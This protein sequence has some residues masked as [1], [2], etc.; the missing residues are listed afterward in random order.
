MTIFVSFDGPKGVG[1]TTVIDSVE[2]ELRT[3]CSVVRFAE[4]DLDPFRG[5]SRQLL[6]ALPE[7]G[8]IS[9]EMEAVRLLARGRREITLWLAGQA[10]VD[11]VL[12]DRWYPSDAA[13]RRSVP[14]QDCLAENLRIDV[15]VPDLVIALVCDPD[16]A[17]ARAN[18]RGR[19]LDS[20]VIRSQADHRRSFTTFTSAAKAHGW[21]VVRNDGPPHEA[22][23]SIAEAVR[24][25]L[26]SR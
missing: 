22:A 13:L 4:K 8:D 16:E 26:G 14:F 21:L 25:A 5:Q 6:A 2:A 9:L 23:L 12:M 11:V 17:W 3:S 15:A 10:G 18:R 19:G 20:S 7:A 1:K 24:G